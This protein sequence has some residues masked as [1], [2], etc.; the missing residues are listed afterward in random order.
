MQFATE[1]RFLFFILFRSGEC[2][3]LGYKCSKKPEIINY[4]ILAMIKLKKMNDGNLVLRI[5]DFGK[6]HQFLYFKH[7]KKELLLTPQEENLCINTFIHF[8]R[9]KDEINTNHIMQCIEMP[10]LDSSTINYDEC[11][12]TLLPTAIFQYIDYIEIKEA[13]KS[14]QEAKRL[15]WYAIWISIFLGA[16]QIIIGYLQLK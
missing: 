8:P 3:I 7:L 10:L 13:R 11:L 6:D 4:P 14:A 2:V 1:S 15:S 9:I 5:I 16:I 12:L